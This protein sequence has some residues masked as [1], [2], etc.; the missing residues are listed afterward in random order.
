[1]PHRGRGK[2]LGA[3]ILGEFF[4]CTPPPLGIK[5]SDAHF[6]QMLEF[7]VGV[8][9]GAKQ[10]LDVTQKVSVACYV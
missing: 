8:A 7:S 10:L 5:L 6:I 1:M 2:V 3:L 9:C 4:R